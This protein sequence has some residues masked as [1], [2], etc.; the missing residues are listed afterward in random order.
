MEEVE[1]EDQG[2]EEE[3]D[4]EEAGEEEVR[5]HLGQEEAII[6]AMEEAVEP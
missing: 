2:R 6:L 4:L 1:G 3:V 5:H